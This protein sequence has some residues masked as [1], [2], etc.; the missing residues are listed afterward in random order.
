MSIEQTVVPEDQGLDQAESF[1]LVMYDVSVEVRGSD[2][3]TVSLKTRRLT[4]AP[5]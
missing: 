1:G 4:Q 3:V 2:D 5:L